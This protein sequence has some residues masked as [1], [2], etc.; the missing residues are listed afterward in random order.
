MQHDPTSFP[1][2]IS[3]ESGQQGYPPRLTALLG[4]KAPATL[5]CQGNL[6]LLTQDAL[7]FC[8]SRNVTHKGLE[9]ARDCA[10][11]AATRNKVVVSGN[12]R[13]VDRMVHMTAL[14]AGGSTIFV[15]PEGINR[16]RV[17]KDLRPFWD[18]QRVL[19]LSEFSPDQPWKAWNAMK[20]NKTILSLVS[21]MIV[22]EAG[23][24]GG[25]VAAG[26]DALHMGVPLFVINRT[27]MDASLGGKQLLDMGGRK[28]QK[29]QHTG[30]ANMGPVL[31]TMAETGGVFHTMGLQ[32]SLL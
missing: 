13:G 16:F 11:Q 10:Q 17:N 22:I 15:L 19:V 6:Q 14:K 28:L 8:G 18:W 25:T 4:S 32:H 2:I 3:L 20:R 23:E 9:I 26:K 21:A 1:T 12:A 31:Q 5:Y 24:K 30:K 27:D 29:S 7:G